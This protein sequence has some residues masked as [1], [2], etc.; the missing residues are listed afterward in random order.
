MST[1]TKDCGSPAKFFRPT[2]VAPEAD[3]V[4]VVQFTPDEEFAAGVDNAAP[5]ESIAGAR[6]AHNRQ[7]AAA[8]YHLA[9]QRGFEPGRELD[10]W[11]A[12]E[13]LV[14]ATERG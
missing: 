1:R 10:D 7:V 11:L 2:M 3:P 13:A 6:R 12:A 14:A 8:A 4:S 9:E 5:A